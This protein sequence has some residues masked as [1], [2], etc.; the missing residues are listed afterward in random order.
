[1]ESEGC[2]SGIKRQ[3]HISHL[4]KQ[5]RAPGRAPEVENMAPKCKSSRGRNDG[6]PT[7]TD[8][9][10]QSTELAQNSSKRRVHFHNREE[11]LQAASADAEPG[12]Q[13]TWTAPRNVT[14]T[15]KQTRL[16]VH[17]SEPQ[18]H[19]FGLLMVSANQMCPPVTEIQ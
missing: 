17:E 3:E 13:Q 4:G 5:G 1:M 7:W 2:L 8:T 14:T 15:G 6:S 12:Q 11:P 16:P 10:A 19:E 18:S 9:E